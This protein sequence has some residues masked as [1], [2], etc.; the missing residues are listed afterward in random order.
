MARNAIGILYGN[1][2]GVT[3]DYAEAMR[4]YRIAADHSSVAGQVNIRVLHHYGQGVAKDDNEARRWMRLAAD[5]GNADA[6]A[7]LAQL[8]EK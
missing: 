2:L 8:G 4:W 6:Q 1:G 5:L 3:V 7:W